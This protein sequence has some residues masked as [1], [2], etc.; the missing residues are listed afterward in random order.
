MIVSGRFSYLIC[1]S[2]HCQY[3]TDQR[4]TWNPD[5]F[6]GE[7]LLVM[8]PDEIWIPKVFLSNS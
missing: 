2:F 5:D 7:D 4:L 3:W 6:E 1:F 8:Y